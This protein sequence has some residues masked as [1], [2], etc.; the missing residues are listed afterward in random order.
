MLR[1]SLATYMKQR[2]LSNSRMSEIQ[3][4]KVIFEST[5][6]FVHMHFLLAITALPGD[7]R[8]ASQKIIHITTLQ[9]NWPG[10]TAECHG[11]RVELHSNK[12]F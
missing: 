2:L 7:E 4:W 5:L 1:S 10:T 11:T 12:L 3:P 8:W 6:L 9:N